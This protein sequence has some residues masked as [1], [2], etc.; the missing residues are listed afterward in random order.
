METNSGDL[1][2]QASS[3]QPIRVH[4]TRA[5]TTEPPPAESSQDVQAD[6]EVDI[7]KTLETL[8]ANFLKVKLH[9]ASQEHYNAALMALQTLQLHF[10]NEHKLTS[11]LLETLDLASRNLETLSLQRV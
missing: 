4:N 5:T 11:H 6:L 9:Q 2:E 7:S 10:A 1:P 8:S 3:T